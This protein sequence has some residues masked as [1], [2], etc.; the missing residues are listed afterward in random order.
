MIKTFYQARL[1]VT[2]EI[3]QEFISQV[4]GNFAIDVQKDA[5]FLLSY[6]ET[7]EEAVKNI[8]ALVKFV[9]EQ[10]EKRVEAGR[11]E[12]TQMTQR[13]YL[14]KYR[15][16]VKPVKLQNR[17]V[18]IPYRDAPVQ[19]DSYLGM[20]QV[21][22]ESGL[23]FGTGMHPTTQLSLKYLLNIDLRGKKVV[24]AGTGSGILAVAAAKLGARS[25]YAFDIDEL[26]VEAASRNA[27][28]NGV[29]ERVIVIHSGMEILSE[30]DADVLVANLTERDILENRFSIIKSTVKQ[31]GLSGFLLRDAPALADVFKQA[32]FRV[33]RT[34]RKKGWALLEL[35]RD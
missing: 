4:D 19:K 8:E 9:G 27:K 2:E 35:E 26:A 31:A 22:V 20:T 34:R 18:V 24:D 11:I 32:G 23:A 10:T 6:G 7:S 28:L 29:A 17:L 33:V 30:L 21:L 1:P 3:S 13:E 5:V 25:V 12:V 14:T 16:F 15:E